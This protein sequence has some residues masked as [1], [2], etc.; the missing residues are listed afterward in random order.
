MNM[1]IALFLWG[2]EQGRGGGGGE[3][4]EGGMAKLK[5]DA[6]RLFFW[7]W[8]LFAGSGCWEHENVK[9]TWKT[10]PLFTFLFFQ[11]WHPFQRVWN[12]AQGYLRY[13]QR[14]IGPFWLCQRA[15]LMVTL[16]PVEGARCFALRSHVALLPGEHTFFAVM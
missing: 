4:E 13:K 1:Y 11:S 5:A 7:T 3:R 15:S 12:I 2:W 16:Y 6:E 10:E 14:L 9:P 8:Q